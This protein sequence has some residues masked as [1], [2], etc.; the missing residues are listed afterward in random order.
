MLALVRAMACGRSVQERESCPRTGQAQGFSNPGFPGESD[1]QGLEIKASPTPADVD[2]VKESGGSRGGKS[3]IRLTP[4]PFSL[5]TSA[6]QAVSPS[7][8]G[9]LPP[10]GF[11]G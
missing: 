11:P 9:P 2:R 5:L 8:L 4:F 10:G 3:P 6:F 7:F 1:K